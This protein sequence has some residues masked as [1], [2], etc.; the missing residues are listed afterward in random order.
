VIQSAVATA[1]AYAEKHGLAYV[2][3]SIKK[4]GS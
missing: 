2:E 4:E 3:I 1:F